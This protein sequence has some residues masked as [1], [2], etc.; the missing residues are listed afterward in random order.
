MNQVTALHSD[1]KGSSFLHKVY[2]HCS[3][4]LY[5]TLKTIIPIYKTV[6][7]WFTPHRGWES[8]HASDWDRP[9]LLYRSC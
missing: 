8:G 1:D 6:R 9:V 2:K 7:I 4:Q 5:R 3:S